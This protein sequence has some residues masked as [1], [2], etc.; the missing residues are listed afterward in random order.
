MAFA[1]WSVWNGFLKVSIRQKYFELLYSSQYDIECTRLTINIWCNLETLVFLV[2]AFSPFITWAGQS[3]TDTVATPDKWD[4]ELKLRD[5]HACSANAL[6]TI[7][8][9]AIQIIQFLVWKNYISKSWPIF[10]TCFLPFAVL[11]QF[12]YTIRYWDFFFSAKTLKYIILLLSLEE[13]HCIKYRQAE[14][15]MYFCLKRKHIN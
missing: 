15:K 6:K 14:R 4:Q 8:K 7:G 3:G 9:T 11:G 2:V 10:R 5:P 13:N 1:F 12:S